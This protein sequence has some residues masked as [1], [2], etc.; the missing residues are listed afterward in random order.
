M[1]Q[2]KIKNSAF[3]LIELL[4]V[5]S[6]IALLIAILLPALSAARIAAQ[7]MVNNTQLR[8][9]V[10]GMTVYSLSNNTWFPGI[11][12]STQENGF[13]QAGD[14]N[15]KDYVPALSIPYE[16]SSCSYPVVRWVMMLNS[17]LFS[18]QYVVNPAE[19]SADITVA[20][21]SNADEITFGG[22]TPNC[23][24]ALLTL[25]SSYTGTIAE[26]RNNMSSRAVIAS[27]RAK[28]MFADSGTFLNTTSIWV[29]N[30][31]SI[32]RGGSGNNNN[33]SSWS[34][35]VVFG[36]DHVK[37]YNDARV[38][39]TQYAGVSFVL[40]ATNDYKGDN[41]FSYQAGPGQSDVHHETVMIFQWLH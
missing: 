29:S 33:A 23:S 7:K 35:S 3:T 36:D 2:Q 20:P 41:I 25:R 27:D 21:S 40:N 18:P 26:W 28:G 32:D 31:A 12:G 19:T 14:F 11:D 38:G 34:G 30:P 9:I 22:S 37:F 4:V 5:I 15:G 24:Y 8:G 16:T 6:I 1:F 39:S 10:Q 13:M 17:H